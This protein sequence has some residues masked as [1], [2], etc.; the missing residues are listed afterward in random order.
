LPLLTQVVLR[1][2][3][4]TDL[5]AVLGSPLPAPGKT[6]GHWP[7]VLG[8][9][10]DEW[11]I[12]SSPG[13][14]QDIIGKLR[15]LLGGDGAVIDVSGQR[16]TIALAGPRSREMVAKGCALDLHP[17][18]F[19]RGRCAQTLL[20]QAQVVL[21]AEPSAEHDYWV[22]PRSS[23]A[24]YIADWLLDAADEYTVAPRL[25]LRSREH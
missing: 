17:R 18:V 5:N 25:R 23:F 16:T 3:Q 7:R 10:P 24:R 12:L 9:G 6:T 2:D 19:G 22:L 8:L 4:A 14:Q 21:V 13:T 11:L 15:A 1:A 20:G